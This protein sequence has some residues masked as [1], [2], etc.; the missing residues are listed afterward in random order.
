MKNIIILGSGRSGTSMLAGSLANSGYNLGNQSNYLGKNKAN[1]K[2]FF[3]DYEVN[4]INE[5]IL[6]KSLPF[7]FNEKIRKFFFSSF[8][9]YRARW[10]ANIPTFYPIKSTDTINNR[11]KNV[12]AKEPFCFKD[13]RFS[14]TLPIW[15]PFLNENTH[16]LVIFREPDKTAISIVRECKENEVL[17]SLKIDE[18]KALNI[19]KAMYRYLLKIYEKDSDKERWLFV[20]YN[21]IFEKEKIKEIETFIGTKIDLSF[22]DSKI[23]RT[24]YSNLSINESCNRVYNQLIKLAN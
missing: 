3:E 16:F 1:P 13:P 22:P 20:H 23:S 6:K 12:I 5:D 4:T 10:L 21:Q 11:I 19:W 14:Y 15:K 18:H 17:N 2:G 9:F 24:N 7:T 8:T